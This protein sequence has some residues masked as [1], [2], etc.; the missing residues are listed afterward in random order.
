M[1]SLNVTNQDCFSQSWLLNTYQDTHLC[2]NEVKGME[3]LYLWRL[4]IFAVTNHW[5][6][7]A[8]REGLLSR[9]GQLPSG[10]GHTGKQQSCEPSA[11]I[12]SV[13]GKTS[14][15]NVKGEYGQC[16]ITFCST[17]SYSV[18][19]SSG[20]SSRVQVRLF[21]WGNLRE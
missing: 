5:M 4:C 3:P 9:V 17:A 1:E 6:C 16:T 10:E 11:D 15:L 19:T 2:P 7:A 20:K 14:A 12:I 8:P 18:S 13:S 21:S